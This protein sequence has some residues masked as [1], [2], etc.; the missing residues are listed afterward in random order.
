MSEVDIYLYVSNVDDYVSHVDIIYGH[1]M[2][3]SDVD[4]YM[5]QMWI[6]FMCIRYGC[7]WMSDVDIIYM[8]QM[9]F[10]NVRCRYYLFVSDMDI[11]HV[12]QMWIVFMCVRC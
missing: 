3:V 2:F 6:L 1:L 9:L 10:I 12:C 5:C 4:I 7:L 11:I 8:C